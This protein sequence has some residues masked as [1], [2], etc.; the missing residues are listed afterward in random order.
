MKSKG[1]STQDRAE[2]KK[3]A[4]RERKAV[5]DAQ[6][7]FED[8]S[9]E[10]REKFQEVMTE[11]WDKASNVYADFQKAAEANMFLDA[12]SKDPDFT[13]FCGDNYILGINDETGAKSI[14]KKETEKVL[15]SYMTDIIP[16][17]TTGELVF[18][19]VQL[20]NTLSDTLSEP[21]SKPQSK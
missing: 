18:T 13:K 5:R 9:P 16:D 12:L 20:D 8:M 15:I 4:M 19:A 14:I 3:K 11:E 10:E 21:L 1:K 2:D 6:K 7:M 17:E